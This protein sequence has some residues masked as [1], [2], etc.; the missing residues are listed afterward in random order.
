MG[1]RRHRVH[2]GDRGFS[3]AYEGIRKQRRPL[4]NL[5]K[6]ETDPDW[7]SA[8]FA[9]D[10]GMGSKAADAIAVLMKG[11]DALCPGS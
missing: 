7:N 6:G 8:V 4:R 9:L 2:D 1:T 10:P 11:L 5:Q 3:A